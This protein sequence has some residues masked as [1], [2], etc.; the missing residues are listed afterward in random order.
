MHKLGS[1]RRF[2]SLLAAAVAASSLLVLADAQAASS[3]SCA[4]GVLV[5]DAANDD[6]YAGQTGTS[7][8]SSSGDLISVQTSLASVPAPGGTVTFVTK[9]RNLQ[10]TSAW[11]FDLSVTAD[12]VTEAGRVITVAA[13]RSTTLGASATIDGSAAGV[14]ATFD[15]TTDEITVTGPA[16]AFEGVRTLALQAAESRYDSGAALAPLADQAAGDCVLLLDPGYTPPGGG[17]LSSLPVKALIIDTGVNGQHQEFGH[18]QIFGWWDFSGASADQAPDGETWQDHDRDGQL[19]GD[20]DDPYDPDGHG[21]STTSMLAGRNMVAS[22]TPSACP[23]CLVA[24]AKVF[25]E[26]ATA[27][28]GSKGVLDGSIG[29]A[30]RWGVDT[31]DVDVVSVSIGALAPLPRFILEETYSAI[32]Y[33]HDKGVMVLFANGNGWGNAGIPGQPGGF[34]SYGNSTDLLSVGADGLDSFLV[35]TD[36]EVVAVF[37]VNAAGP[38]G[39]AYQEIAG[40]SFSTP[41]TAGVAAG[42]IG[43]GRACGSSY[44][45]RPDS[46]EWLIKYTAQDRPQVPPSFEGYGVVTIKTMNAALGV[47]CHDQTLP[48][49]NALNDFYVSYVSGT[50][51]TIS[52]SKLDAASVPMTETPFTEVSAPL[53]LGSSVPAGPKDAEVFQVDLGPGQMLTAIAAGTGGIPEVADFDMALFRGPGPNFA[54]ADQL[55]TS[56]KSGAAHEELTWTNGGLTPVTVS[57]VVYGWSIVGDQPFTLTG[58]DPAATRV[59]DGYVLADNLLLPLFAG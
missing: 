44:D 48:T 19:R 13:R 30:I 36:P 54:A 52:S 49:P 16:T 10:D 37:N 39:N 31:L 33:A 38:Q 11:H 18:G 2:G 5:T 12:L 42:L 47:V 53:V 35:T 25:N 45:L 40:T 29:E 58:L 7:L 22:K 26:T 43:E 32:T 17:S 21:S 4:G 23:G 9:V 6:T 55:V 34:M 27:T 3:S 8:E 50:E 51:R 24:V 56:G 28:D 1:H 15:N 46:I 57:L 59:F 20:R 41:F 14:T